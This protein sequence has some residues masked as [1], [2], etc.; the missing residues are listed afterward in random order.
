MTVASPGLVRDGL[1]YRVGLARRGIPVL[2]RHVVSRI[3]RTADGL[4]VT[5]A[6]LYGQR[7]GETRQVVADV[8]CL[9][10]G[11]QPANE[12]LRLLGAAQEYDPERGHLVT[13]RTAEYETTIAG[14]YAVGDCAGLGGA[15]AACH[16]GTIAGCAVARSLGLTL[17]A[18][19]RAAE[20]A[21]RRRLGRVRGF[22]R[23]LWSLFAAPRFE[24]HLATPD[25]LLCRCEEVSF[26]E[27]DA[28]LADGRPSIAEVKQ[29]TRIGMGRC[30]G[31]YCAPVLAVL[32]AEQQGR[33]LDERAF[34]APRAPAKPVV[35][36]D[37]TRLAGTIRE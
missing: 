16:E 3:T 15:Q 14:V 4:S 25:T 11:F 37:L 22:E 2:F 19:V 6:R 21:A 8:A 35:I 33:P 36:G 30:Q 5:L 12:V 34:F 10:Y 9:G 13:R 17:S 29:R 1:R 18:S 32:L 20:A 28:A 26:A 27:I 24:Y 31:R 23:T 7:I